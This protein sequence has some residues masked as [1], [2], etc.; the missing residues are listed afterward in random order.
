MVR[1]L[2]HKLFSQGQSGVPRGDRRIRVRQRWLQKPLLES[3][4]ER[5]L[6]TYQ[7]TDLGTLPGLDDSV[8][9]GINDS[10]QVVGASDSDISRPYAFLWDAVN[11]MQDL[12]TL[13]GDSTAIAFGI[14]DCGQ[15]VGDSRQTG[16]PGHAFLWDATN[17]MQDLGTLPGDRFS[18]ANGINDSGEVVGS[19]EPIAVGLGHA[20]LWDASNGMQDLGTLPG[21]RDS[22]AIA[23]NNNGQVVGWSSIA[24]RSTH[25][26]LWDASNG[27]QDLGTLPGGDGSSFAHGINDS[28]Q[29]VGISG[30]S[31]GRAFLWDAS[32]GMQDLGALPG[33]R[34]AN[35][36]GIN[37]TGQVVGESERFDPDR[38]QYVYDA[39]VWQNGTMSDLNDLSAGSDLILEDAIAIN[40]AGQIVGFGYF[41]GVTHLRAYLLTP[42]SVALTTSA[43]TVHFTRSDAAAALLGGSTVTAAD[44]GV[45]P[46]SFTLATLADQTLT[47]TA[48]VEATRIG[49]A[50]VPGTSDAPAPEGRTVPSAT[51]ALFA[52]SHR[53]QTAI[54]LAAWEVEEVALGLAALQSP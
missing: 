20:F 47:V 15:V 18:F 53:T 11:G 43:G 32:N 45:H 26:F 51:D 10:G 44:A 38:G 19:A 25:A 37:S 22:T 40:N 17:G 8:A 54:P 46:F 2:W 9:R 4:E 21:G 33:G 24:D 42:D 34:S 7:V 27:M 1:T 30:N 3:L 14:N 49:R 29:V 5:C 36:N 35:A 48:T 52:S 16:R 41:N 13:P 23:I 50:K 28:G 12:G 31:N 6:L 39:F